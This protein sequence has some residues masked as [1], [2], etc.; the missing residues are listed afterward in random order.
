ME[1]SKFIGKSIDDEEQTQEKIQQQIDE[2]TKE[3]PQLKEFCKELK[4]AG[5]SLE[6]TLEQLEEFKNG[7]RASE[8][9]EELEKLTGPLTER[10]TKRLR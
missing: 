4:D 10:G 5:H 7:P 9:T 3:D 2:L 1:G 6:S 8:L